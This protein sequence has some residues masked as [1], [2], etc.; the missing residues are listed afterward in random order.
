MACRRW[1][2][3]SYRSV[4][5]KDESI[6]RRNTRRPRP[7]GQ[8][9]GE[10]TIDR[11]TDGHRWQWWPRLND[12]IYVTDEWTKSPPRRRIRRTTRCLR[13]C[14][15]HVL[16]DVVKTRVSPPSA[17][18]MHATSF[19]LSAMSCLYTLSR[20]YWLSDWQHLFASKIS[21]IIHMSNQ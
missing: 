20:K 15:L 9:D 12:K 11:T 16:R 1:R 18:A 10:E 17:Y 7:P 6:R 13:G 21:N 3:A 5:D 14:L 4:S 8:R 2:H 19:D